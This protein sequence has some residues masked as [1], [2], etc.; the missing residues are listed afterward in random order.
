MLQHRPL[1]STETLGFKFER[2]SPMAGKRIFGKEAVVQFVKGLAKMA[3]VGSSSEP[4]CGATATASKFRP[5]VSR[6]AL[7]AILAIALKL[8]GGV[9]AIY[10]VITLADA[11]YQRFRWRQRLR[12]SRRS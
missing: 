8:M 7:P 3:V 2:V 11:L 12:M 1:S 9:L 4:S 5:A 6:R 10:V